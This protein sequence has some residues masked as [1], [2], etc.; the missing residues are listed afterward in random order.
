MTLVFTILTK[1]FFPQVVVHLLTSCRVLIRSI[2]MRMYVNGA[3]GL[4][5]KAGSQYDA[6]ASIVSLEPA[7]RRSVI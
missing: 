7:L 4:E 1:C 2:N 5:I 6:R 3:F